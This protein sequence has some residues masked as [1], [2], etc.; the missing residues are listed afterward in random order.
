MGGLAFVKVNTDGTYKSSFDKFFNADHLKTLADF[1]KA[2]AGDLILILAG[3]EEKTRKAIS[4]LRLEM[5]SAW[6]CASHMNSNCFGYWIFP[7][8]NM[9]KKKT[10]GMH[11]IIHLLLQSLPISMS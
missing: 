10:A 5:A 8:L 11:G 3:A 7:C 9:V 1:C 2:K 4:E 6:I